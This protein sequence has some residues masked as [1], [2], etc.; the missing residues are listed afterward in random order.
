MRA[1]LT[2]HAST[3]LSKVA[4]EA[5][6]L[7][8]DLLTVADHPRAAVDIAVKTDRTTVELIAT[9]YLEPQENTL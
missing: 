4:E 6:N 7:R 2:L 1:S 8:R 9:C 3:Q 5:E